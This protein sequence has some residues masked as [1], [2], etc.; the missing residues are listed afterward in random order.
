MFS[1]S[2]SAIGLIEGGVK[3][4]YNRY[5]YLDEKRDALLKWEERLCAIVGEAR[6]RTATARRTNPTRRYSGE[7]SSGGYRSGLPPSGC[8]FVP[9][10]Q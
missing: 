4:T 8:V 2:F 3:R 10:R 9:D 1:P 7:A 6:P 5:A